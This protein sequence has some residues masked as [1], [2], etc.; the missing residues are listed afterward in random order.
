LTN[1]LR[2]LILGYMEALAITD[3]S[4]ERLLT[5][6]ELSERLNIEQT[7]LERQRCNGEG[8]PYVRISPRVIRYR[9]E[10]VSRWLASRVSARLET[11]PQSS[12]EH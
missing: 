6:Q 8:P 3:S 1:R 12:D 2:I 9:P 10:D 11:S 7:L 5:P 4:F